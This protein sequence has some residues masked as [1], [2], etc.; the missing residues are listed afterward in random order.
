MLH[1]YRM[2]ALEVAL[3]VLSIPILG[4]HPH[5]L[6][7]LDLLEHLGNRQAPF[8]GLRCALAAQDLR[9]DVHLRLVLGIAHIDHQQRLMHVDLR[10]RKPDARRGVHGLE[11]VI[12]QPRQ[13]GVEI[14]HRRRARAQPRVGKF[15]YGQLR[16]GCFLIPRL[17]PM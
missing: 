17:A 11:H 6:C 15:Q 3:E 9:V 7:A 10:G 1:A 2:Q 5:A 12:D 14:A 13:R 4:A 8:L 16:H